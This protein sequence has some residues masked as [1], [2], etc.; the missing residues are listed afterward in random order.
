MWLF[1]EIV[2][3]VL[4]QIIPLSG[5]GGL[6]LANT[7]IIQ[8]TL[9]IRLAQA[10]SLDIFL[11]APGGVGAML[12]SSDN[13]N[14]TANVAM[15]NTIFRTDATNVIGSVGNNTSPFTG[16]YRPEGTISTPP[17]LNGAASPP[18]I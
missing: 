4:T 14:I 1:P 9:N 8:V 11:V 3:L 2:L 5:S 6:T 17:D 10:R 16:T 12:L 13:G 7:D 15:T 18:I